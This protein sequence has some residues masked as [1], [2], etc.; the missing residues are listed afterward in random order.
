RVVGGGGVAAA[1]RRRGVR[2]VAV[3]AEVAGEVLAPAPERPVDLDRAG[4]GEA[5][6]ERLPAGGAAGGE[7]RVDRAR[8]V[9]EEVVPAVADEGAAV[10]APAPERAVGLDAAGGAV[11]DR[12]LGPGRA[13]GA[14]RRVR[15]V[16]A[17]ADA[18]LPRVV[19]AP[20]EERAVRAQPAGVVAGGDHLLEELR[21]ALAVAGVALRARA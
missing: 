17:G 18:E 20:A 11:G 14:G 15:L 6:G 4:V 13:A 1:A 8:A 9:A 5:H 3:G 16:D 21:A 12:H 10:V 7:G 19:R 2:A